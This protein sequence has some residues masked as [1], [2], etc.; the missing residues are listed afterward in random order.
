[1]FVVMLTGGGGGGGARPFMQGALAIT[2]YRCS[3]IVC[4]A[5]ALLQYL[6]LDPFTYY[7]L[8]HYSWLCITSVPCF[9]CQL[10][11]LQ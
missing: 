4:C 8:L 1:M 9:H 6:D 7:W 11:G 5:V 2:A 10:H 3:C